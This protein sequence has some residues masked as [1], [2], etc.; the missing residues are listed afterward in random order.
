MINFI[1]LSLPDIVLS[2]MQYLSPGFCRL[3]IVLLSPLFLFSCKEKE[4]P[5]S[6][7][8]ALEVAQKI[9]S[10]INKK[11]PRYFSELMDVDVF[12][13]RIAKAG[14][15]K[16]A[17]QI[18]KEMKN[19]WHQL[20]M[21]DKIVQSLGETGQYKLVK[22]YEKDGIHHLIFRL[23][24]TDGLNYHDVELTKYKGKP[25]IA[26]IYI[27][28]TGESFSKTVADLA[29]AFGGSKGRDDGEDIAS[30]IKRMRDY[31]KTGEYEKAEI[32]Y[33]GLPSSI[34]DQKS[35]RLM[36]IMLYKDYDDDKYLEQLESFKDRFPDMP[37]IDLLMI[38]A[39][40]MRKNYA[41]AIEAVDKL[42]QFID[43]DPFLD[44]YRGLI[45]NM[46]EKT[47]EA[48]VY[49]EKTYKNY[50]DFGDVLLELIHYNISKQN[51]DK[52]NQLIDAYKNNK[53]FDQQMLENY[54]ATQPQFEYKKAQ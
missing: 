41:R 33:T 11:Q 53:A 32:F 39:Y 30:S 13:E 19:F 5:L 44:F 31:I 27:Y 23:Y 48:V 46:E 36:A 4:Q 22:H 2:G 47:D 45:Y 51:D 54:L 25:R 40:I 10:S 7:E 15:S 20:D 14:D 38:D 28:L 12:S 52:A 50:P 49:F 24:A 16:Y 6:K 42:D 17:K 26:D 37:N 1:F 35:V 21:G 34:K 29:E 43:K 18:K 8:E 3:L 9:D